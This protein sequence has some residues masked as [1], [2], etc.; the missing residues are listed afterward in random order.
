MPPTS[1]KRSGS[2]S[3]TAF[4][5]QRAGHQIL[6]TASQRSSRKSNA[7]RKSSANVEDDEEKKELV[8]RQLPI[9]PDLPPRP[10]FLANKTPFGEIATGLQLQ[11]LLHSSARPLLGLRTPT[12]ESLTST[13]GILGSS[14]FSSSG[15][16][17]GGVGN[18]FLVTKSKNGITSQE[19]QGE[20]VTRRTNILLPSSSL[21]KPTKSFYPPIFSNPLSVPPTSH[22][23]Q[24]Q[25]LSSPPSTSF[26][27]Q[28]VEKGHSQFGLGSPLVIRPRTKY[29]VYDRFC[30]FAFFLSFV[31][32][33]VFL[34]IEY[35]LKRSGNVGYLES[36]LS[37]VP[38]FSKRIVKLMDIDNETSEPTSLLAINQSQKPSDGVHHEHIEYELDTVTTSV[39]EVR[40][41]ILHTYSTHKTGVMNMSTVGENFGS[42]QENDVF[43]IAS[44]ENVE[45][46]KEEV[47]GH[48]ISANTSPK[49]PIQNQGS[50]SVLASSEDISVNVNTNFLLLELQKLKDD[51]AAE[52]VLRETMVIA[53]EAKIRASSE[54]C[55]VFRD[56]KF[57]NHSVVDS[58]R[59][60]TVS[61]VESK[62][63][64]LEDEVKE[65]MSIKLE[66]TVDF[67]NQIKQ[68]LNESAQNQLKLMSE[69]LS[70]AIEA[71]ENATLAAVNASEFA[72]SSFKAAENA[73]SSASNASISASAASSAVTAISFAS[74]SDV[75]SQ[76]L[77]DKSESDSAIAL[78][79]LQVAFSSFNETF[80]KRLN[81]ALQRCEESTSIAHGVNSLGESSQVIDFRL[82]GLLS[83]LK[84]TREDL[85]IQAASLEELKLATANSSDVLLYLQRKD[86]SDVD[87]LKTLVPFLSEKIDL[88]EK[89]CE[90]FIIDLSEL[91]N[92]HVALSK[93]VKE[94]ELSDDAHKIMLHDMTSSISSQKMKFEESEKKFEGT[95]SFVDDMNSSMK[96]MLKKFKV[97]DE[98][99]LELKSTVTSLSMKM[100]EY[101][102]KVNDLVL[103]DLR[104][105]LAALFQKIDELEKI[106]TDNDS[107]LAEL[108]S[109]ISTLKANVTNLRDAMATF[110]D[111]T[112]FNFSLLE[113]AILLNEVNIAQLR[114]ESIWIEK[115]LREVVK[116]Q[117]IHEVAV[118]E[119]FLEVKDTLEFLTESL[120]NQS[121][122]ISY[123]FDLVRSHDVI[124]ASI[125][126]PFLNDCD[127]SQTQKQQRADILISDS[128]LLRILRSASMPPSSPIS[129]APFPLNHVRQTWADGTSLDGISALAV[130]NA[131]LTEFATLNDVAQLIDLSL[132]M[133]AAD[134]GVPLPDYAL[135][136]GGA[137]VILHFT[138]LSW[139]LADA[140]IGD[141]ED[142]I[143]ELLQA[144]SP[145]NALQP[146]VSEGAGHCWPMA[147]SSGRLTVRLKTPIRVTAITIDH[148]PSSVAPMRQIRGMDNANSRDIASQQRSTSALKR[149]VI[150][151]LSG[152][153]DEDE[154]NKMLLGSFEFDASND[155]PPTQTFHLRKF[156]Y[157]EGNDGESNE[158]IR[159]VETATP[160]V[161]LHVLDNHGHPDYTCIYRFRVHGYVVP[162]K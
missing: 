43:H 64:V 30:V 42:E 32:S 141:T 6:S 1:R 129:D 134:H 35:Q 108:H 67:I 2:I 160:I 100:D 4:L 130:S 10:P 83:L 152:E 54:K 84:E 158:D 46:E 153:S 136:Q 107:V 122:N 78:S 128:L 109:S 33:F 76:K 58:E 18:R 31:V 105:L 132:A 103:E 113:S 45:N 121:L 143:E 44:K 37:K 120:V 156:M 70:V 9:S 50:S 17:L 7:M 99:L 125:V 71:S 41:K 82:D 146:S 66:E 104:T 27:N 118:G 142:A 68:Q 60:K 162:V 95:S 154:V 93:R 92:S 28:G 88:N 135:A 85:T 61:E 77:V 149:F 69:M 161:M 25:S 57:A 159:K 117:K 155:A 53:M 101:D 19:E 75:N 110:P 131:P 96:T 81:D 91:K 150:Y 40:P 124:N 89:K 65:K 39:D 47:L 112:S 138:S 86:R 14:A 147:G 74:T 29:L 90:K 126:D 48:E 36:F 140:T 15:L 55:E 106:E 5:S 59:L 3:P 63:T 114:N 139:L 145:Y 73:S 97:Y 26:V 119:S 148:L 116:S 56:A 72:A 98:S 102:S 20:V 13:T 151:G 12:N 22:S 62:A 38:S 49:G 16:F 133:V 80:H 127:K 8:E 137:E 123:L 52:K 87:D 23:L 157:I 115:R 11:P 51:L 34:T 94:N 79:E 24:Q 111:I 21:L 144:S